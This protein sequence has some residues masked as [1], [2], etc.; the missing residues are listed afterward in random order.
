[1]NAA[2]DD[3][4]NGRGLLLY[5]LHHDPEARGSKNGA[6]PRIDLQKWEKQRRP[7]R[8]LHGEMHLGVHDHLSD[9]HMLTS[10]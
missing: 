4:K 8:A 7:V 6:A 1:M 2:Y 10:C 9:D 5:H 3:E